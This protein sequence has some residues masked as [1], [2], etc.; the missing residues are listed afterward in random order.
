[1]SLRLARSNCVNAPLA[2][3]I[4]LGG[5]PSGG[6]ST[7]GLPNQLACNFERGRQVWLRFSLRPLALGR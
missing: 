2:N 5:A 3:G 4:I 1:L 7:S 6:V